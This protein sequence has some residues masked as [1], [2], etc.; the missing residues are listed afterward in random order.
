M[1]REN[2]FLKKI[3]KLVLIPVIAMAMVLGSCEEI[4]ELDP[5]SSVSETTAFTTPDLIE[6]SVVGMYNAAQRGYY[7]VTSGVILLVLP[8]YNKATAVVKMPSIFRLFIVSLM[9]VPMTQQ[10]QITSGIGVI[11]TD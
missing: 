11:L 8:L 3:H 4:I 1:K 10:P 7:P 6:L 5:Y 2:S 9:K